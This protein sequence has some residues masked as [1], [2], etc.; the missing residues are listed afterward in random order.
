MIC[1]SCPRNDFVGIV[2]KNYPSA[3]CRCP[4]GPVIESDTFIGRF[5][6]NK[7]TCLSNIAFEGKWGTI[8]WHEDQVGGDGEKD[9]EGKRLQKF[10]KFSET[11]DF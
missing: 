3:L 5:C 10:S 2:D 9:V 11:V 7:Y 1:L 4:T 6:S 8:G